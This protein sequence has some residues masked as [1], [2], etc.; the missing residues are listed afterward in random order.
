MGLEAQCT[1]RVGRKSATG[2]A[3][4]ETETL[5]F[6]GDI[7]LSIPLESIREATVDGGTLLVRTK[8]QEARFELGAAGAE[9]W[10]R[11]IVEPKGLFEKLEL[12]MQSR[13]AVVDVH[14]PLFLSA[15]R[16]RSVI[17]G[18]GR[19]PH[20]APIIFFG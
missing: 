10:Q 19:V 20:G 6:R 17:I 13:V 11:A 15:L 5:R 14:D 18:E 3:Q 1:L 4:L 7:S 8:D 16:E 2:T 9:H 12:D